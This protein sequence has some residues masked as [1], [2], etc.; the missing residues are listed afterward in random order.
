LAG[1]MPPTYT[2]LPSNSN[3]TGTTSGWPP[4]ETVAMRASRWDRR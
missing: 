2:Y 1:S 3:P 4:A